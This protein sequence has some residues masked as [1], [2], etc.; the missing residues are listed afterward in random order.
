L[1]FVVIVVL[2]SVGCC[3]IL[4]VHGVNK[5]ETLQLSPRPIGALDGFYTAV[6]ARPEAGAFAVGIAAQCL[7]VDVTALIFVGLVQFVNLR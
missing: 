3:Y 5:L 7:A 2:L 4:N 6:V 1:I